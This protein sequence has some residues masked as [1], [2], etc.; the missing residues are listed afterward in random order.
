MKI[1]NAVICFIQGIRQANYAATLAR[2]GRVKEAQQY[3]QG[4]CKPL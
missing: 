2:N 3:A 4:I 1:I